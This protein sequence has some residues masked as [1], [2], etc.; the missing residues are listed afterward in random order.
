MMVSGPKGRL[1]PG[2]LRAKPKQAE[3]AAKVTK[4]EEYIKNRDYTGALAL[5]EFNR[6]GGEEAD[7]RKNLMWIGYCAFHLVGYCVAMSMNNAS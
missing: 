1:R 7:E 6:K 4:L 2:G 3:E 5:L